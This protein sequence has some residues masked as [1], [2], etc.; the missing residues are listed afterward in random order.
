AFIRREG[1]DV[2]D[3]QDLTQEFFARLLQKRDLES[4]R[5]EKGRFRSFLLV[6]LK[7]F[8]VNEW[9]RIRTE[10]RGGGR[11]LIPLDEVLAENRYQREPADERSAD[12]IF[13]RRWALTL[14]ERV[15]GQLREEFAAA[16]KTR[17]FDTLKGFLS[18]DDEPRS[19]AEIAR[20]L[21]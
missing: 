19:Q 5:R 4:V 18:E 15:L 9:E 17:L 12:K 14:L 6:S 10:K 1:W 3:A 8:L 11:A 21:G 16:G 20:E 13:E 2:H 7:H